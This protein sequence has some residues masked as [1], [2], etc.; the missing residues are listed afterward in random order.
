MASLETTFDLSLPPDVRRRAA[1]CADNQGIT[2]NEF[3]NR[4]VTEKLYPA[5]RKNLKN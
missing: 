1:A 5:G 2:L 4:A 3:I